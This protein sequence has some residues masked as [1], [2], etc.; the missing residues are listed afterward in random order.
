LWLRICER[1]DA[2]VVPDALVRVANGSDG[3]R[4]TANVSSVVVGRQL[5]CDKHKDKMIRSGVAHIFFR[6]SGWCQ[7]RR[8]RDLRAARRFY[9]QSLRL[10]PIAPV[11]WAVY[12]SAWLPLSWFDRA[13]EYKRGAARWLGFG[14]E[15]YFAERSFTQSIE[16]VADGSPERRLATPLE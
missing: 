8:V 13:A 7:Q 12:L 10:K 9:L 4:I 1:F 15:A 5:Y 11:T 3:G 6:D 16:P 14:P 2:D